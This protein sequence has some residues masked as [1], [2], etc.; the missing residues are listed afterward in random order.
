MDLGG[1]VLGGVLSPAEKNVSVGVGE[2]NEM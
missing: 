2:T 1:G